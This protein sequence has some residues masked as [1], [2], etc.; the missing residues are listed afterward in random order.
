MLEESGVRLPGARILISSEVPMGSGLGSSAALEVA[1][2]IALADTQ[3]RSWNHS[4]LARACQRAENEFVGS[5]CGIMDQFVA[6]CGK[7]GHLLML[8][9]RSLEPR[10]LRVPENV[11]LITC[12]TMVKPENPTGEYNVRRAECEEGVH[13]LA[14]AF[15]T[16]SSLRDLTLGEFERSQHLLPRTL[17]KRCRHVLRENRRVLTAAQAME[18]C[19]LKA[20]GELMAE[21]HRSLREDYEVS[22]PELDLMVDLA[23]Q[24]KGTYGARMTGGGLGGCTVNL[25]AADA[26]AEF[27]D[28]VATGYKARTG[29]V[30]EIYVSTPCDGATCWEE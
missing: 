7:A 8:D 30:P 2:G 11:R 20:F 22:S 4:Q 5:P 1:A 3:E 16:L 12:N 27:Q 14:K 28:K 26:V 17:L 23:N 6:C 15:P 9:C 29:I 19:D 13:L 21:S 24:V 25:V 10:F 18:K